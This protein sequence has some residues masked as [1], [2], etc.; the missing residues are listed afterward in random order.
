MII[1]DKIT[2]KLN[3]YQKVN[4]NL[5]YLADIYIE[6]IKIKKSTKGKIKS[7]RN[8]KLI[9]SLWENNPGKENKE[10]FDKQLIQ[11]FN[12]KENET[13]EIKKVILKKEISC[14]FYKR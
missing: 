13:F 10:Y 11:R 12:I 5:I 6:I 1:E 3:K 7:T 2:S 4:D 9:D 14:S 8:E